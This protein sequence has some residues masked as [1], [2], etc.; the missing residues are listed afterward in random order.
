MSVW[1]TQVPEG[2]HDEYKLTRQ[3]GALQLPKVP[4]APLST[5]LLL[6]PPHATA[7]PATPSTTIIPSLRISV[8]F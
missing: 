4:P 5:L 7:M 2:W 1:V 3:L 8:S 6:L